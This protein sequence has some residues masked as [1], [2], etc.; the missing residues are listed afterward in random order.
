MKKVLIPAAGRGSRLGLKV[1]KLLVKIKDKTIIS[2]IVDSIPSDVMEIIIILSPYAFNEFGS[3]IKSISPKVTLTI[4]ETPTGMGDAIFSS[5]D[6]WSDANQVVVIWGDQI[7]V[8]K[9][10]LN[11]AFNQIVDKFN[12]SV[13]MVMTENLYVQYKIEDNS[14]VEI[15][16]E[17]E[18]DILDFRGF[19]DVGVF[20][21]NT[22]EIFEAWQ[23]YIKI[24]KFGNFTKEANFLPFLLFLT[25]SS[26]NFNYFNANFNWERLGINTKDDILRATYIIDSNQWKSK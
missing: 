6:L 1:P 22:F 4:Q 11:Q 24:Q 3:E 12:F 5:F 15:L 10:T 23:S 9:E 19:S 26:W 8:Q 21:F 18:G 25:D 20:G 2:Y 16:Q 7:L 13:P 17:R 14:L